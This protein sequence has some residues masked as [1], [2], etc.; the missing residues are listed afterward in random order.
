L[1][2][3]GLLILGVNFTEL[4]DPQRAGKA[5]LTL[6][7]SAGIGPVVLLLKENTGGFTFDYNDWIFLE[8]SM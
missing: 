6:S 8:I 2:Q 4:R 5:L 3:L 1:S 7:A